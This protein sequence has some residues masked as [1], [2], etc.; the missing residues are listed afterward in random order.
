MHLKQEHH[1]DVEVVRHPANRN[2][3]RWA[4]PDQ[5]EL[6]PVLANSDGFV[7]LPKRWVERAHAWYE[8]C[9]RL[10]M[11]HDRRLS[12]S[13][14]WMWLTGARILARR[15]PLALDYVNTP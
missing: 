11:H 2:V 12:V 8:R 6:F 5:G 1:I 13:E 10:I 15:P 7:V 3:G 4:N 9:R 14:A